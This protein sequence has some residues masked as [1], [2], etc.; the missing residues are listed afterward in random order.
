MN[1]SLLHLR[2]V[3]E[4][5]YMASRF[6]ARRKP[7]DA[8]HILIVEYAFRIC[9]ERGVDHVWLDAHR[10]EVPLKRWIG[11]TD[12]QVLRYAL[13]RLD[14][15]G[16]VRY[17]WVKLPQFG[18]GVHEL[19]P[20]F[21]CRKWDWTTLRV[22]TIAADM[23]RWVRPAPDYLPEVVAI[24]EA[25]RAFQTRNEVEPPF[26][27]ETTTRWMQSAQALVRR[28]IG[29]PDVVRILATFEHLDPWRMQLLAPEADLTLVDTW[30]HL[31][32]KAARQA[33]RIEAVRR[34]D[35]THD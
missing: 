11:E 16:I 29:A 34:K 17:S 10:D 35:P 8:T 31:S 6:R 15:Y 19:R 20:E 30:T 26:D 28:A 7:L 24:V 4:A 27:D 21:D 23:I 25:L 14:A 2:S 13:A 12:K 22:D 33:L 1:T 9:L 18:F 3:E 32:N 5:R